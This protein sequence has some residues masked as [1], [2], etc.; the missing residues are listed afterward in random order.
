MQSVYA[1]PQFRVLTHA[2]LCKQNNNNY[3]QTHRILCTCH[4]LK[5]L[6][7]FG[8][9]PTISTDESDRIH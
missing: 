5:L 4:V 9:T 2:L 6:L 8:H 1:S 7:E 3:Q